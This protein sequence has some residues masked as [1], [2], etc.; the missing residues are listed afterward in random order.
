GSKDARFPSQRIEVDF[1]RQRRKSA[2]Y[3]GFYCR[4]VERLQRLRVNL[5]IIMQEVQL[6]RKAAERNKTP[7]QRIHHIRKAEC[8]FNVR[9]FK[10][11]NCGRERD[12]VSSIIE[13]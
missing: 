8:E 13:E 12:T 10:S 4:F 3:S 7:P 6:C 1:P 11:M 2:E 5:H 9:I